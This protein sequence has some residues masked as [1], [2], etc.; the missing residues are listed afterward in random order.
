VL[1]NSRECERCQLD[2]VLWGEAM[3]DSRTG[4]HLDVQYI[5]RVNAACL[6]P[7]F[8]EAVRRDLERA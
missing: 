4:T 5:I 8:A 7:E 6:R 2:L 1:H 3:Y